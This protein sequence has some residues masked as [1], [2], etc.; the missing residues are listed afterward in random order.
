MRLDRL[1]EVQ[2]NMEYYEAFW[3]GVIITLVTV[4]ILRGLFWLFF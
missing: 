4:G 2:H 3:S 1:T